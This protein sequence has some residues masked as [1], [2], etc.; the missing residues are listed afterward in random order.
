MQKNFA[1]VLKAVPQFFKV[2]YFLALFTLV[3]FYPKNVHSQDRAEHAEDLV[4][5]GLGHPQLTIEFDATNPRRIT[6]LPEG[7]AANY[8]TH[9]QG[10]IVH[11]LTAAAALAQRHLVRLIGQHRPSEVVA[12]RQ[13]RDDARRRIEAAERR[14]APPSASATMRVGAGA[15]VL[16][17]SFSVRA[18]AALT[19]AQI[20]QEATLAAYHRVHMMVV[21]GDP[22]ET[23]LTFRDGYLQVKPVAIDGHMVFEAFNA[24]L[25][26]VFLVVGSGVDRESLPFRQYVAHLR[27]YYRESGARVVTL[28]C[29]G[30][31]GGGSSAVVGDAS[32][33]IPHDFFAQHRPLENLGDLPRI[34]EATEIRAIL[35]RPRF[36]TTEYWR[37]FR[38]AVVRGIDRNDVRLAVLVAAESSALV[39]GVI[40]L[41]HILDPH[42]HLSYNAAAV[43]AVFSLIVGMG[44]KT[45]K[46]YSNHGTRASRMAKR[47]ALSVLFA[48][49]TKAG[50]GGTASL[51]LF[52]EGGHFLMSGLTENLHLLTNVAIARFAGDYYR[53]N[54]VIRESI[55]RYYGEFER[56]DFPD[57]AAG[58]VAHFFVGGIKRELFY[59]QQWELL[60]GVIRLVDMI[61]IGATFRPLAGVGSWVSWLAFLERIEV[62]MARLLYLF[63]PVWMRFVNYEQA[64]YLRSP[65]APDLYASVMRLFGRLGPHI[66]VYATRARLGAER[67]IKRCSDLLE[68]KP[69]VDPSIH[70][71]VGDATRGVGGAAGPSLSSVPPPPM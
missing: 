24:P 25:G 22:R 31:V 29:G 5:A 60:P 30:A 18:L 41:N 12:L 59:F 20:E 69:P 34:R 52:D 47:V 51:R 10:T 71:D 1:P 7:L 2:F 35:E 44:I 28:E 13:A 50:L 46:N 42:S 19:D 49:T 33:T 63:S 23:S 16:Q 45:W 56:S 27:M 55:G 48:Y 4:D 64:R 57:N 38:D 36:F 62:T 66:D 15:G 17:R 65:L 67:L 11:E 21:A 58:R 8:I 54:Y 40:K 14:Q 3:F 43:S 6:P 53:W 39:G 37:A 26:T 61:N 9:F 70:V 68:A 32:Q